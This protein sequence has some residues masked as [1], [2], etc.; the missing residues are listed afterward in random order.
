MTNS[1]QKVLVCKND[2]CGKQ[3]LAIPQEQKFYVT[4]KL[5]LPDFCPA[6]RH[7]QRMALRSERKLYG[8]KCDK[9]GVNMLSTYKSEAP[10]KVY[11]QKCFWENIV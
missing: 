11:C 9:C 6:C 4:K 7:Q 8:R 5:P 3:F 2:G 10:Y 1:V